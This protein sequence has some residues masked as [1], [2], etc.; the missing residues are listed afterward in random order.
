[1]PPPK[2]PS[3]GNGTC[4]HGAISKTPEQPRWETSKQALL[5]N[6]LFEHDKIFCS[7]LFRDLFESW[8]HHYCGDPAVWFPPEPR[9]LFCVWRAHR[10]SVWGLSQS[11]DLVWAPGFS[12][13]RDWNLK[14]NLKE[15]KAREGHF[16]GPWSG[17]TRGNGLKL[18]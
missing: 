13:Q 17:R 12:L 15:L 2:A 8:S 7:V 10:K 3:E 1:M 11:S 9:P 5:K 6:S 18:M 4:S 16:T 14:P